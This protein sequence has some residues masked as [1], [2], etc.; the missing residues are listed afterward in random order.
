MK[1]VETTG[2]NKDKKIKFKKK[3]KEKEKHIKNIRNNK[4]RYRIRRK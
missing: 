2:I 1:K 4:G 3:E